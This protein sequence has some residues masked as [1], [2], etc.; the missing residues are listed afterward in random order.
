[1]HHAKPCFA[2]SDN[3]SPANA[4]PSPSPRRSPDE[5]VPRESLAARRERC[6]RKKRTA[7]IPPTTLH[8]GVHNHR[9]RPPM[10]ELLSVFELISSRSLFA[11]PN[12]EAPRQERRRLLA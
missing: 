6:S 7:P 11:P 9:L 10:S 1:P 3:R 4:N 8:I 5:A 2:E 12:R